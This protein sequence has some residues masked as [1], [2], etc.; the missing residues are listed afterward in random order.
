MPFVIVW[1]SQFTH[2][3]EDVLCTEHPLSAQI[4]VTEKCTGYPKV[5]SGAPPRGGYT[6]NKLNERPKYGDDLGS[7]HE[8]YLTSKFNCPIFIG[9]QNR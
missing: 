6:L 3:M 4:T 1:I 8:N 2:G 5:T 7:E 9:E